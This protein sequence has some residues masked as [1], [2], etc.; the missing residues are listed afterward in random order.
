MTDIHSIKHILELGRKIRA[1]GGR[2]VQLIGGK[3]SE[4]PQLITIIY[5]LR[6]IGLR[7]PMPNQPNC[8]RRKIIPNNNE[9]EP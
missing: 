4:H 1:D 7:P 9:R 5:E 6:K 2:I 8:L 3:S